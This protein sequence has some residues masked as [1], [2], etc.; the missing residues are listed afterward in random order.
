MSAR[1]LSPHIAN[2]DPQFTSVVVAAGQALLNS[3]EAASNSLVRSANG[4]YQCEPDGFDGEDHGCGVR[5][6][7]PYQVTTRRSASLVPGLPRP[8]FDELSNRLPTACRAFCRCRN[9]E[10]GR[11]PGTSGMAAQCGHASADDGLLVD[12]FRSRVLSSITTTLTRSRS[13]FGG[14]PVYV[15]EPPCKRSR[16]QIR[17]QPP[18][19]P[20]KVVSGLQDLSLTQ[21]THSAW[22]RSSQDLVSAL[23]ELG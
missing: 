6:D 12:R 10:A 18:Q 5:G 19:Q 8:W 15:Q 1:P 23:A 14:A 9:R 22:V 2:I 21:L 7:S 4:K 17:S 3:A 20:Q 16:L 11:E 13:A